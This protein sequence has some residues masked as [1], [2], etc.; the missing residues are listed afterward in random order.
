[1]AA[2]LEKQFTTDPA[3]WVDPD[4]IFPEVAPTCNLE[5]IFKVR[6]KRYY[7]R[8]SSGMWENDGLTPGEK[9][10]Y[11]RAMKGGRSSVGGGTGGGGGGMMGKK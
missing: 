1:L 3:L 7:K 4:T 2:A 9:M 6:K 10:T 11:R 8:T 5:E